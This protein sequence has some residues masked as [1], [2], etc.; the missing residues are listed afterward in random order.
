M[1]DVAGETAERIFNH[2]QER[3]GI[4]ASEGGLLWE[5]VGSITVLLDMYQATWK[6]KYV[7][8]AKRS[9]DILLRSRD[10]KQYMPNSI[11]TS[12]FLGNEILVQ[13]EGY[14]EVAWGNRYLLYESA[15][16]LIGRAPSLEKL[17]I[18]EADYYTWECPVTTNY[19][20]ISVVCYAYRFTGNLHYAAFAKWFLDEVMSAFMEQRDAEGAID[21]PDDRANGYIP[22]LMW[23]VKEA[24]ERDPEAFETT[25]VEWSA[26][27]DATPDRPFIERPDMLGP[28]GS[29]YRSLGL[30]LSESSEE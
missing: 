2:C 16:R 22:R 1:F 19:Y 5:Y 25:C 10:G 14:P 11:R 7:W 3:F 26:K 9:L 27:R 24:T 13:S 28:D 30:M 8:L 18:D 17:I 12:G 20:E 6:E 23:L 15:L 21:P 29:S 4:I